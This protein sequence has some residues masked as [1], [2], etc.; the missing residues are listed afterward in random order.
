MKIRLW[1]IGA[2]FW[3]SC[4]VLPQSFGQPFSRFLLF[5]KNYLQSIDIFHFYFLFISVERKIKEFFGIHK[6]LSV[7]FILSD[8]YYFMVSC[9]AT[10]LT[11]FSAKKINRILWEIVTVYLSKDLEYFFDANFCSFCFLKKLS[12]NY[13]F[14]KK[15]I[16]FCSTTSKVGCF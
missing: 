6:E 4:L 9:K 3:N 2:P 8:T 15:L 10:S 5:S 12:D 14:L 11:L 1:R 7:Y 16:Q 13:M